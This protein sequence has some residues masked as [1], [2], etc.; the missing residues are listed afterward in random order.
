MAFAKRKTLRDGTTRWYASY[1]GGDGKYHMEGGFATAREATR[2]AHRREEEARRG[3]W[4]DPA[5]ARLTFARYVAEYYWPTAQRLEVTTR[6]AYA[7][8]LSKHFLP[9]LGEMPMRRITA[10]TVQAWVNEAS[11]N[12]SPTSSCVPGRGVRRR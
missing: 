12:L 9:A 2:L 4:I 6:A 8:Y 3:E 11:S 5:S 7:A 1:R 10:S